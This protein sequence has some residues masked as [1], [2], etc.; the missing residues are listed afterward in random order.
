[1]VTD[2]RDLA[3][4]LRDTGEAFPIL[5]RGFAAYDFSPLFSLDVLYLI[6]DSDL[7]ALEI[8]HQIAD[9]EPKAFALQWPG[10]EREEVLWN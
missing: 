6:P 8:A 3:N 1:V 5:I 9:V 4:E 7:S 10:N 2:D